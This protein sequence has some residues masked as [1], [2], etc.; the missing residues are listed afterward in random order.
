[1]APLEDELWHGVYV[2]KHATQ[3]K[4]SLVDR[5]RCDSNPCVSL[6]PWRDCCLALLPCGFLLSPSSP[7]FSHYPNNFCDRPKIPDD[8]G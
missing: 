7:N 5:E 8:I 3:E 2:G 6:E 4:L 1:M